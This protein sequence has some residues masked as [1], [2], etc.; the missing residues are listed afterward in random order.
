[1]K[2]LAFIL[3]FVLVS[4]A[5]AEPLSYD[6]PTL[7]AW[8]GE[9]DHP[10]DLFLICPT[11]DIGE[12]GNANMDVTDEKLREHFM[13]ALVQEKGLYDQTCTLYA[14]YYLQ[15]TFPAYEGADNAEAAFD[16]AYADI[17]A[18]F[19]HYLTLSDRPFI[20]A[21]FSQGGQM[22]L[23]L[24]QDLFEDPAVNDRL[25]AAYLVSPK[26][27]P[28]EIFPDGCYHLYDYF[29]FF[30]NLQDNVSAR[31]EAYLG[32]LDIALDDAA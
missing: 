10:I 6:D 29:F 28:G 7:W 27:Y 25:V 16:F 22:S 15:A 20:L 5:F 8:Q 12:D 24:L 19:E 32:S 18:A 30:R 14:P 9:G 23:R 26:D 2:K 4:C 1:M 21:G 11:V 13:S 31:A 3:L 17:H